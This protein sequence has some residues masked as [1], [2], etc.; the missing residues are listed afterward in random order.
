[1]TEPRVSES[2]SPLDGIEN[3]RGP[4]PSR[5]RVCTFGLIAE[6]DFSKTLEIKGALHQ[7]SPGNALNRGRTDARSIPTNRYVSQ[8]AFGQALDPFFRRSRMQFW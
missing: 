8:M 6:Q 5:S 4:A 3:T 1:M 2:R 7:H